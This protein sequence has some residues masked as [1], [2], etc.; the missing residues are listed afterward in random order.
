M[1]TPL[2]SPAPGARGKT[3]PPV[4]P[5]TPSPGIGAAFAQGAAAGLP[6]LVMVIPFGMVFGMVATEAGLDLAATMGFSIMVIA[7]ASQLAAVQLMTENAPA[8]VVILTA[9]A[10][11][12]RMAMYSASLSP[13]LGAAPFWQRGAMAYMLVDQ[14]YTAAH[15][16]YETGSPM[17]LRARVAFYFGTVVPV[18]PFWYLATLLGAITGSA[19]PAAVPLEFAVPITF[20]AMIAPLL[21]TLAHVTAALVSVVAALG[22]AFLPYNLGLL[23]AAILSMAAGAQVELWT[24]RRR[25]D[26]QEGQP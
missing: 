12:L 17:S 5:A 26:A 8:L 10:V 13:W 15:M 19:I 14:V 16:R 1:T 4:D 6:F 3:P 20:M 21:R 9:L 25:A 11:N 2:R 23:A 22:L 24:S 18:A 7:G